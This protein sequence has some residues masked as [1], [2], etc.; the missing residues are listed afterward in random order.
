[1]R[2]EIS[3]ISSSLPVNKGTELG[4]CDLGNVSK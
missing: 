2:F 4:T 3:L 1:M